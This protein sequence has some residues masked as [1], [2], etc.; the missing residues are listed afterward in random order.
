[1]TILVSIYKKKYICVTEWV[2]IREKWCNKINIHE[3]IFSV[4][5]KHRSKKRI[6]Y[7]ESSKLTDRLINGTF[8]RYPRLW[9]CHNSLYRMCQRANQPLIKSE[10]TIKFKSE[11]DNRALNSTK[12][13]S[14][15]LQSTCVL[16]KQNFFFIAPLSSTRRRHVSASGMKVSNM[17]E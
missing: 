6:Y 12:F 15:D 3:T 14:R 16:T 4:A 9:F 13:A 10:G 7:C 1:M 11:R 17:R 2:K 8:V 5:K